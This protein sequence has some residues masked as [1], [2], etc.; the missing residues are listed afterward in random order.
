MSVLALAACG[1][2]GGGAPPPSGVTPV[3]QPPPPPD[4]PGAGGF[5][6]DREIVVGFPELLW[7]GPP[8][9]VREARAEAGRVSFALRPSVTL[10]ARLGME[11]PV[12]AASGRLRAA[13][14]VDEGGRIAWRD[15]AIDGREL[16]AFDRA[17]LGVG[18]AV[19]PDASLDLGAAAVRGGFGR[20]EALAGV[21]MEARF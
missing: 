4:P 14:G 20:V 9:E 21:R 8:D 12:S 11:R 1:G 17:A 3:A 5:V 19:G 16:L 6:P 18:F 15:V 10:Q 7:G 2:G 13:A